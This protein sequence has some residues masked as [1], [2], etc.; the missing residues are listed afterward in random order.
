M[1]TPDIL[2]LK[3]PI[4]NYGFTLPFQFELKIKKIKK[5][6]NNVTFTSVVQQHNYRAYIMLCIPSN[7]IVS[8]LNCR[9]R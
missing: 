8:T 7:Q 3:G 4:L 5:I 2:S 6:I 9:P 1:S